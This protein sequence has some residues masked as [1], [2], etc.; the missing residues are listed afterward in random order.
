MSNITNVALAGVRKAFNPTL[1]SHRLIP[2]LAT[3]AMGNLG[4]AILNQLLNA[5]F[6][7]TVLTRQSSAHSFPS[8]VTAIP[9]DYDSLKLL[10]N[11]L[12]G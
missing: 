10:T 12:K 5:G 8:S 11:A 2:K 4:S 7:V 1:L 6:K 9:V 3:Q